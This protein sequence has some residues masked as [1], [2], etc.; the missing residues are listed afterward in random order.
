M[1]KGLNR[2]KV[3]QF[4]K[5]WQSYFPK[6]SSKASAAAYYEWVSGPWVCMDLVKRALEKIARKWQGRGGPGLGRVKEVY[7]SFLRPDTSGQA[8]A[9][10]CETCNG[11]GH[12]YCVLGLHE[13][14][15]KVMVAAVKCR[16]Y[17]VVPFPC[18]CQLG[19][20]WNQRFTSLPEARR[21]RVHNLEVFFRNEID[22]QE[23]I[24]ECHAS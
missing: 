12:G 23:F 10:D 21:Q 20:R 5:M 24:K 9:D 7:Q 16:D 11:A 18:N 15:W 13:G 19:D 8:H 1:T 2:Q 22:A 3:D 17:R 4:D 14:D 6:I